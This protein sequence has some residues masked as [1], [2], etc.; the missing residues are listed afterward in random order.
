MT[1]GM[2]PNIFQPLGK[3]HFDEAWSVYNL[4]T[5][6]G[7]RKKN[8][9]SPLCDAF[10]ALLLSIF[11]QSSGHLL[12]EGQRVSWNVWPQAPEGVDTD[13]WN[14]HA[15]K[16]H[17]SMKIQHEY[18]DGTSIQERNI[19]YFD[20][21][22]FKEELDPRSVL[23]EVKEFFAKAAGMVPPEKAKELASNPMIHFVTQFLGE[24]TTHHIKN[25]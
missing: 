16:W 18:P 3:R 13:E 10:D 24:R 5:E 7:K 20:G 23:A 25:P 9:K 2:D 12:Q 19:T 21:T 22:E 8:K 4:E 11:N 14:G 6:V 15:K 1:N 17:D